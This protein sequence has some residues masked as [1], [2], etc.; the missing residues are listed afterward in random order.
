MQLFG[1]VHIH[2]ACTK[3]S[4]DHAAFSRKKKKFPFV[5]VAKMKDLYAPKKKLT[6]SSGKLRFS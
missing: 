6:G 1:I 5:C 2:T 3:G 4:M